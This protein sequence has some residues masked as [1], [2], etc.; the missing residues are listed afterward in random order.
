[1]LFPILFGF[2]HVQEDVLERTH[3]KMFATQEDNQMKSGTLFSTP[4]DWK[5]HFI[6]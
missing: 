2:L 3:I 4:K 6:S 1:M 5:G